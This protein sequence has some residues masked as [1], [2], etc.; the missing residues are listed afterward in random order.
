MCRVADPHHL[1]ADP[2]LVSHQSDGNLRQQA[3]RLF[4]APCW[5][6]W[7][8]IFSVHGPHSSI[9]RLYSFWPLTSMRIRIQIPKIIWIHADPDPRTSCTNR[10]FRYCGTT[11]N[12][13]ARLTSLN[14][15]LE[16][17]PQ[18]LGG[19]LGFVSS[20]LDT[21]VAARIIHC[22][23]LGCLHTII[24]VK[25]YTVGKSNRKTYISD[26]ESLIRSYLNRW[27][28]IRISF[29]PDPGSDPWD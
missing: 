26:P 24:P 29:F 20:E 12:I 22:D 3:Y 11:S 25:P 7:S 2:D 17:I 14:P 19:D 28:R 23:S 8:S 5:D 16:F 10:S 18:F 15:R 1:N 27:V 9:L 13:N 4:R 6:S 21:N